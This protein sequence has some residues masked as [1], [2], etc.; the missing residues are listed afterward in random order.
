MSTYAISDV[1]G[2]FAQLQDLLDKV[3]PT[4]EDQVYLLG[5]LLDRGPQSVEALL[6]ATTEAPTNF[7]FLLG[8]HE[9][10]AGCVIGRDPVDIQLR[11]GW[12]RQDPWEYNGGWQTAD[13]LMELTDPDWRRDVL[14]PWLRGLSPFAAITVNELDIMLVHAGFD[15]T[16][17]DADAPFWC[18]HLNDPFAHTQRTDVGHGFGTQLEQDMI[19]AREGWYDYESDVPMTTVFGHTPTL[20]LV[21]QAEQERLWIR[22]IEGED[23]SADGRWWSSIPTERGY[24]WRNDAFGNA[25]ID[26]D[27]GCAYGGRLAALRLDDMEEFYV[28]GLAD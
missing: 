10:M 14:D 25:R 22:H 6:W 5:D 24:I 13:E 9:D 8:N 15:P 16:Q 3:S 12:G 2:C 21:R 23:A 4:E 28:D 27:C 26:I 7:H 1:H 17:W 11:D 18:D 20:Y 19:W